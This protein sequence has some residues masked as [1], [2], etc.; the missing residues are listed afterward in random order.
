MLGISDSMSSC[1]SHGALDW[2]VST[3]LVVVGEWSWLSHSAAPLPKLSPEIRPCSG[4]LQAGPYGWAPS[5]PLRLAVL[6]GTPSAQWPSRHNHPAAVDRPR[7]AVAPAALAAS[8]SCLKSDILDHNPTRQV[9]HGVCDLVV[10]FECPLARW[11][12]IHVGSVYHEPLNMLINGCLARS[13]E[14]EP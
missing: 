9:C 2:T 10:P 13:S 3:H 11:A 6:L 1:D 8:R 14:H 7:A 5:G 12:R 4:R